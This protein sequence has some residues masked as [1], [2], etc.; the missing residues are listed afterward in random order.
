MEGRRKEERKGM[1]IKI[2]GSQEASILW[3]EFTVLTGLRGQ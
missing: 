2:M 3:N 1:A